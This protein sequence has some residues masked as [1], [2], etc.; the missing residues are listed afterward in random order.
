MR[1]R[2]CV[3]QLATVT[4]NNPNCLPITVIHPD[5]NDIQTFI[6]LD[7]FSKLIIYTNQ[8]KKVIIPLNSILQY[9]WI[10]L[11]HILLLTIQ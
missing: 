2:V 8:Q 11:E 4:C 3:V 6:Q 7:E 9:V 1:A 5:E 10:A